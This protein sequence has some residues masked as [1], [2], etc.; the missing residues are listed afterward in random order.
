MAPNRILQ[1]FNNAPEG[2]YGC[3]WIG[4][5]VVCHGTPTALPAPSFKTVNGKNMTA[6]MLMQLKG[7]RSIP[8]GIWQDLQ[9]KPQAIQ[10]L[11]QKL[12]ASPVSPQALRRKAVLE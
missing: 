4:F 6:D 5:R 7:T 1:E 12:E 9:L 2:D 11:G 8:Q 10:L 3:F